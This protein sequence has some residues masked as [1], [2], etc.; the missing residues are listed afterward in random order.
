MDRIDMPNRKAALLVRLILENG[1]IGKEK[2][3]RLFPELTEAEIDDLE[4]IVQAAGSPP[5]EGE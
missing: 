5:V 2:R 1:R 4:R 3:T